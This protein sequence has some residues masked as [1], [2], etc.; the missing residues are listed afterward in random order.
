MDKSLLSPTIP[1]TAHICEGIEPVAGLFKTPTATTP[2]AAKAVVLG[3]PFDMGTSAER[4]GARQGPQAIRTQSR[5]LDRYLPPF[6]NIDAAEKLGLVDLGDATVAAGRPDRAFPEM[7]KAVTAA[8]G[9]GA[10]LLSMGGDG[11]IT[12]PQLRALSSRYNDLAVLHIDAHTDA[13]PLPSPGAHTTATTFTHA[14]AE[15]LVDVG[16]SFHIGARGPAST[17]LAIDHARHL[18]YRVIDDDE[19]R[20]VGWERLLTTLHETL[21]GRPV[22]VCWDMD[23]FDASA[24][25]GVCDP[26]WGGISPREGLKFLEGL[27]G[28]D[29]VAVDVNTVAPAFDPGGM[30]AHLAATVMLYGLHLIAKAP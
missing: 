3:L 2:G 11:S 16:Q 10:R 26:T 25:P 8:T 27:A 22:Y 12:L 24:A 21:K 5:L 1:K 29:I 13:F 28:L 19:L 30:T 7:E 17:P 15:H 23:V 6:S 20:S 9:K 14:A 4:P 18:G